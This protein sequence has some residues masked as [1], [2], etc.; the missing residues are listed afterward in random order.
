VSRI[1]VLPELDA[2]T[3]QRH[4]LH[5]DD[6]TWIE[7]NCYIDI[8]IE[9]VHALGLDPVAMLAFTIA[10]DFEDDQWTFF[11]PVHAEIDELYGVDVQE[12]N[13]WRSLLEHAVTHVGAGKLVATEADAWWL[14]DTSGTDYRAQHT[15]TSIVINDVDVERQR[16]G[17]FHNAAYHALEGED[18]ERLFRVGAPADPAFMPLFAEVV[19]I[20]RRLQRSPEDLRTRARAHL[21]RHLSRR[22]KNNPIAR[23]SSRVT[24]DLPGIQER[25]L[26]YY[27]TWAFANVRQI[28]AAFELAATHLRW[29]G[30]AALLPAAD[31]FDAISGHAKTLILKAARAVNTKK[32]LDT[33][34]F[35]EMATCWQTAMTVLEG[36]A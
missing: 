14:P 29:H 10:I 27:H 7:K 5:A 22:P 11:K 28:G 24:T 8:W 35:G 18:F 2:A 3:Y 30:A 13:V 15:K 26:A 20:D 23:F 36:A 31:A 33:A 32:P 9:L 12:L 6:R 4:T 25:G 16:L 1:A 19:R 17:Y 34:L 21:R